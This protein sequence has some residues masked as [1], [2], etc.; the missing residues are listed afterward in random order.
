MVVWENEHMKDQ[1]DN[2]I[3]TVWKYTLNYYKFLSDILSLNSIDGKGRCIIS[4]VHVGKSLCNAYWNGVYMIYGDG[5]REL[6]LNPFYSDPMIIYHELTHGL[7]QYRFPLDYDGDSGAINEHVADVFSVICQH[8]F[9]NNTPD[10][11]RWDPGA[12]IVDRKGM[13]LRRFD[14]KVAFD[15]PELGIDDQAKHT[16]HYYGGEEDNHGVHINSGILNYMFY[17]FCISLKE[18]IWEKPLMIWR[19][20]LGRVKRDCDFSQFALSLIEACD[21]KYSEAVTELLLNAMEKV[22]LLQED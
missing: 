13:S 3:V 16:I 6:S 8:Y 1:T 21:D 14:N 18:K 15:Y 20:A 12:L 17:L 11:G 7:I 4:S 2:A 22:G 10:D 19:G 5:N 9:D